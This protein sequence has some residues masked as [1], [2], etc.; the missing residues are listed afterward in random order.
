MRAITRVAVATLAASAMLTAC[1]SGSS[2]GK[3]AKLVSGGTLTIAV[4]QDPGNLD[5]QNS[6]LS[7]DGT[8]AAFA[9]DPLVNQDKTGKMVSGLAQSWT[10]SGNTFT[11]TM[12]D[13]VTCSDGTPLTAS[14]VAANFTYIADPK[15]K[16]PLLG[17]IVPPGLKASGNDTAHTVTLHLTGPFPFFL[18]GMT[19]VPIVCQK[20]LADRKLL[21][22]HTDGTGAYVLAS[23]VSGDTYI[24]TVR[25]GYAWGPAGATTQPTG[26]PAKLKVRVITN[27]STATNLLLAG[28]VN[29]ADVS[30][31]DR[32]RVEAQHL[33]HSDLRKP[34]GEMYF[35]EA[36][37]R[38]TADVDVRR[39]LVMG[40]DLTKLGKVLTSGAGHPSQGMVTAEPKPCQGDP[41]TGNVPAHDPS[42]AGALLDRAGWTMGP[43]GVRQKGGKPLELNLVYSSPPD[44]FPSTAELAVSQWKAIGVQVKAVQKPITQIST[45]LFGTGAFDISWAGLTVNLPS[46]LV[47]FLSGAT[48]PNGTNFAHLHNADYDR[49]AAAAA[50][51]PGTTGCADWNAAETALVKAVDVVPYYD[52]VVPTY[53]KNTTFDAVNGGYVITSLRLRAG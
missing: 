47:P 18:I 20:G 51:K 3:N 36:A 27:A 25:K 41:V 45:V 17:Q 22:Q 43:N 2:G 49:L 29:I 16:S 5:P 35:N 32:Q 24:Y 39:A 31:A 28:Q 48:P 4:A 15:N 21:A 19:G 26:V 7:V 8:F 37:G 44:T 42:G 46:Q 53:A 23:A 52:S 6:A 40:L 10:Q 11:F 14:T 50:A 30:D 34:T 13:A 12:H 38:P 1:S 33:I 9:Y